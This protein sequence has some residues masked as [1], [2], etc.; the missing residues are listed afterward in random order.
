VTPEVFSRLAKAGESMGFHYV[1]AGPLVRSSY[2]AGEYFIEKILRG[3]H[4]G[5]KLLGSS[6]QMRSTET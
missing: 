3:E 5:G 1:A 4:S 2:R 6:N